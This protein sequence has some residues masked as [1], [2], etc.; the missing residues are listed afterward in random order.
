MARIL[1][2][3]IV[4]VVA[5]A[6]GCSSIT[7]RTDY[8]RDADFTLYRTF[9][10]LPQPTSSIS[11]S[12][13]QAQ[14]RN[15]LMDKRILSAVNN[16]LVNRGLQIDTTSP[17]LLLAYHTGVQD[18]VEVTDWGYSYPSYGAWG[19]GYGY[20]GYGYGGRNIDVYS[21]QEGTFI[22]DFIDGK[23]HRLVWRGTATGVLDTNPNPEKSEKNINQ[24]VEK[25]LAQYP[26]K[27]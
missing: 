7:V 22:L 13:A 3:L 23:T 16:Q 9:G 11:G 25:L 17:D 26:P 18:K 5:V 6:A 15:D 1:T 2:I 20:G 27:R 12:A 19:G 21:Y 10:W 24:V 14:A 4:A 8:D